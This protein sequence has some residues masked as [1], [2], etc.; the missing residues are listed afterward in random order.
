[1]SLSLRRRRT[2]PY[3]KVAPLAADA[4]ET[5]RRYAETTREWAGP[6]ASAAADWAG[7]RAKDA[8]DWAAPRAAAAKEWAAPRAK[9]AADWA[10]PRAN[11][12][13]DWAAPRVEPVVEKVKADVLPTVAGAVST[14]LV[15]SEP[16]RKEAAH[17][18]SAALAA[19][20]GELD[21]PKPKKHRLRKLLVL[22]SVLGGAYAGWKAWAA[23]N[24][25]PVQP[26]QSSTPYPSTPPSAGAT[27][28]TM[29]AAA[30]AEAGSGKQATD[31]AAGAGPDE[32]LADAA[33]EE[34]A[35]EDSTAAETT[36]AGNASGT[37]D[38][39]TEKVTPAQ[40]KKAAGA[41]AKGAKA[42]KGTQKPPS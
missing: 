37:S 36:D 12:A 8:A 31:D 22:A 1:M 10:A 29:T 13:K 17:R 23:K 16:A 34:A 19:L 6:R 28:P 32:A 7:P 27:T 40:S 9:D 15:A 5:A 4:R 25:D 38:T 3:D 14:A 42:T 26:W 33:A 20:K 30:P 24:A 11:A 18:G 21:P 35:I 39:T 41:A 2:T